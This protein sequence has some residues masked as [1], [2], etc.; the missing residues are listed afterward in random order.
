LAYPDAERRDAARGAGASHLVDQRRGQAGA[1]ATKRVTDR[2]RAAAKPVTRSTSTAASIRYQPPRLLGEIE[3]DIKTNQ[4]RHPET[5]PG[6]RRPRAGGNG[7][8][9]DLVS[10]PSPSR[11]FYRRGSVRPPLVTPKGHAKKIA[12]F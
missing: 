9:G 8:R 11:T 7:R 10:A 6:S 12:I 3:A 5:A 1:A 4:A 2:N